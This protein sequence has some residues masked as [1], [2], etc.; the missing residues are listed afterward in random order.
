M[1]VCVLVPNRFW[2]FETLFRSLAVMSKSALGRGLGALL[3]GQ[4][5]QP[6]PPA[7]AVP[8]SISIA[9]GSVVPAGERVQRVAVVKLRPCPF[10]PRKDFPAAAIEELAASIRE[11]GVMQPLIVR[12]SLDG[13]EIIAGERRWRAAQLAGLVELPVIVR[14]ADDATVL[15]LALVE[16]LQRENLNPLEESLGFQQLI[17]QFGLTQEQAAQKVGKSRASVANALRLLKL[18]ES[19]RTHL[20]QGRLSVGHAK[21]ILGLPTGPEQELA[22]EKVLREALNV[23]QT[24]VLIAHWSTARSSASSAKGPG[25]PASRDAH[26]LDLESKLQERFGTKVIIRYRAGKGALEVRFH[27][28]DELGRILG[29]VGVSVD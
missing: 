20:R 6:K 9:S 24:E 26:V 19:V 25:K 2:T 13:F 21:V 5:A 23:R 3:G 11:Q 4:N 12:T 1:I 8:G 16:N 10:Q 15:E 14:E 17:E 28:D 29:I 22:A 7:P 27:D 18:P